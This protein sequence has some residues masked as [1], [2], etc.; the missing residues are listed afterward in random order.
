MRHPQGLVVFIKKALEQSATAD[1]AEA[2]QRREHLRQALEALGHAV[3]GHPRLAQLL[4]S[5]P[6]LAPLLAALELSCTCAPCGSETADLHGR[7]DLA[8]SAIN[9]PA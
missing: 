9:C 3:E 4:A 5:R 8:D 6:A 2:A 1:A 7:P